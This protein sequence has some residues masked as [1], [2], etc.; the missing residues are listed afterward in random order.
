MPF[1]NRRL[2]CS[3]KIDGSNPGQRDDATRTNLTTCYLFCAAARGSSRFR[4]CHDNAFRECIESKEMMQPCL[5][6]LHF[7][8]SVKDRRVA[9]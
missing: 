5:L 6:Y 2:A 4:F 3:T 1:I 8:S 9:S 7:V